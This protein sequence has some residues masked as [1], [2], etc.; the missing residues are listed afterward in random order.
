MVSTSLIASQ[1]D[2]WNF[3]KIF[4]LLFQ[5]DLQYSMR[6]WRI[7]VSIVLR[8]D[9]KNTAF[10]DYIKKFLCTA[11][12]LLVQTD[13][14]DISFVV[15]SDVEDV[16][17]IEQ[18][19]EFAAVDLVEGDVDLQVSIL[20]LNY[21]IS[22]LFKQPEDLFSSKVINSRDVFAHIALHCVGLSRT[23]LAIGEA[24]NL[25][26]LES[27]LN[28]R[29]HRLDIDLLI[30]WMLVIGKIKVEGSLFKILSQ[31]NFLPTSLHGYLYSLMMTCPCVPILTISVSFL[32]NSFLLRGRFLMATVILGVSPSFIFQM[33]SVNS[34]K[35]ITS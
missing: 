25:R 6:P 19:V 30:I 11:D 7:I 34:Y 3:T 4:I 2:K 21:K 10:F 24:G 32:C 26:S 22:Y 35:A 18:I 15:L 23:C 31:V 12:I 5:T 8:S 1:I 17:V 28:Q 13:N 20:R 27:I 29:S 14:I 16:S 33:I 9:S